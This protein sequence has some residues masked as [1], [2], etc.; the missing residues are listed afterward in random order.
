MDQLMDQRLVRTFAQTI[1]VI[2]S[3]RHGEHG[4]LLSELGG[5]LLSPDRAPAGTKRIK[6]GYFNPP[7][8]RPNFVP[9]MNWVSLFS[10]GNKFGF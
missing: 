9:G 8:G 5:Y 10:L 7:G 2:I 1:V 6:P 3:F 4:L